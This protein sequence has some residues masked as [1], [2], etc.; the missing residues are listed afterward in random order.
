MV[1]GKIIHR[2]YIFVNVSLR[3]H[4]VIHRFVVHLYIPGNQRGMAVV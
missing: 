1:D 3:I 4:P 2:H